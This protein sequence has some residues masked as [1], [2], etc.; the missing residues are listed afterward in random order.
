[1]PKPFDSRCPAFRAVSVI[2]DKWTLMI[3]RDLLLDGPR[4]FQDFDHARTGIAPNILSARL[5][6]LEA[7]R[8][9][10]RRLY[11]DH[12]PRYTYALTEKGRALA[13][14]LNALRDWG[15]AHTC[16]TGA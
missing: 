9:V 11:C 14:V 10:T 2:G 15:D 13:P 16:E 3:V 6:R 7:E 8:V 5:K 4:R 12:P 1:M